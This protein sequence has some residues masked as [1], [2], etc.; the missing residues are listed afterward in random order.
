MA[1]VTL[2]PNQAQDESNDDNKYIVFS[3][4]GELYGTR[5][6]DV[7]E[8][9]EPVYTKS[10]PNTVSFFHGVCN[11]RGQ[12]IGV[13][14][15]RERFGIETD[16]T[17][18]AILMVFDTESGAIAAK[19]DRIENVSVIDP[20]NIERNPNIVT[21]IPHRYIVGIA[22]FE[23]RLITLIDLKSVLT[24]EEISEIGNSK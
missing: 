15:L 14:G 22:K 18:T 23:N 17:K 7:R 20:I 16:P 6:L 24:F 5:L 3:L 4:N 12:I 9:V 8:V 10:V 11:L 21:N 19:A 2:H 13:I 1:S